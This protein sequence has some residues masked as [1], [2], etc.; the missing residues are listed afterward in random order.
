MPPKP[1]QPQS[2]ELFRPR[3]DEQLNMRHSLIRL[4]GLMDWEQ[5]EQHFA[6]HFTSGR[7]RPALPP[8]LVAGLLY[9][10]HV[11]DAS[12]EAVVN[13]WLENP[14][15]QFFCGETYLQTELPIDPSSLTRWR[16][17]IGEE[18][19]E[20]LLAVTIEAARAAGLIDKASV[21]RVIVDTTV[22][23]KA[24]AH[25]TDSR[26][27]ERSRQHL[28]KAAQAHGIKLRQNYNRVAPRLAVQVGRY[29]HAKQ[30]KRMRHALR[31]LRSRVGRVHRDVQRQIASLP[32]K[33]RAQVQELLQRTHRILTQA[34][35][36]KNKLYALHAPEVEC[37]GKGKARTPYE[38][39]V[40][41][42]VATTLKEGV[43]VGMRSMPGN[44]YDGH[45]L[46]QALEQVGILT[47]TDR[48]PAV[49]IV[50]KGYKGV[51]IEGVRILRSGQKRGIT[52]T[53]K[54]MI[55]RRSAIEPAIGHMKM[56]GC[57]ARNPLKGALGDAIHA[58]MCGAG[59]NLRLILAALRLLCARFGL[60]LRSLLRALAP[61]SVP[62]QP[63][64]G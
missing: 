1:S 54:A 35:K 49:A 45:T 2:G 16:Q 50:D 31:T 26:L 39:G 21:Q 8:R 18:G 38:F 24:I 28:V 7:G 43:V 42:S 15:W 62:Q 34:P 9:L 44:P 52:K 20:V 11:N 48:P 22:M 63:A 61:T 14:Y 10:Q 4:S 30:F 33:A 51:E 40:K 60:S 55:K 59:H 6:S 5:I 19:V 53:L 58:V 3:L 47:G 57:L 41:V 13:T 64:L 37:I 23:P 29:A 56:D 46:A 36:D 32:E 17:R 27:L 12:D 25:P